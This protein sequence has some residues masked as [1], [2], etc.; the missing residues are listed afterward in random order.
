MLEKFVDQGLA[1]PDFGVPFENGRP[2][3]F[4]ERV[5]RKARELFGD[6]ME[7]RRQCQRVS[8]EVRRAHLAVEG[9]EEWPG[10]EIGPPIE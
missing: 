4:A 9:G 2:V 7:A 6:E 3:S 5:L 8:D 10:D 1:G